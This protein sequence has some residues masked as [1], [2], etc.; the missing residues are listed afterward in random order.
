MSE[1]LRV[2]GAKIIMTRLNESLRYIQHTTVQ[3]YNYSKIRIDNEDGDLYI[4]I[5]L[6]WIE[7]K[8]AFVIGIENIQIP[9]VNRRKG[10]FTS[11]VNYMT[12]SKY[13]LEVRV[14]NI[15]TQE[16]YR[17]CMKLNMEYIKELETFRL[18]C[19]DK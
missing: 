12:H 10:E 4:W 6:R 8:G 13:C 14:C 17:A 7:A 3:Q 11:L 1:G 15:L 5:S 19:S 16:M 9:E 18:I 2:H